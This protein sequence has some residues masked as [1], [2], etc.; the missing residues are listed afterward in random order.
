MT[1]PK[2]KLATDLLSPTDGMTTEE[3]RS[4]WKE[5]KKKIAAEREWHDK[6]YS[7][8]A[9]THA[10]KDKRRGICKFCGSKV[11]PDQ[12]WHQTGPMMIG[13]QTSGYHVVSG[14]YCINEDCGI[15]YKTCP[16]PITEEYDVPPPEKPNFE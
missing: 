6:I 5:M 2:I 13:G 10:W 3:S 15:M 8:W 1:D 7:P 14:F 4:W 16:K 11:K 9:R 12:H